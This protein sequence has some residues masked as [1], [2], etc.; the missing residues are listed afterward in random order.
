MDMVA[1]DY[2]QGLAS[3][4]VNENYSMVPYPQGFSSET[5]GFMTTGFPLPNGAYDIVNIG[6][7]SFYKCIW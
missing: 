6:G 3:N 7:N 2:A 4:V 1:W 5:M